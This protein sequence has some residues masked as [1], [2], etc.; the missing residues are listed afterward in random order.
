MSAVVSG[1][2]AYVYL[3]GVQRAQLT[4]S[5]NYIRD[6]TKLSSYGFKSGGQVVSIDGNA[7][8]IPAQVPEGA[9][10]FVM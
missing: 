10:V 4:D 1:G 6:R 2:R 9:F 3:T 8:A 5:A 7:Y